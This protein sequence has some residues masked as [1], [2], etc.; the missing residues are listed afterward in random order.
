VAHRFAEAEDV[1]GVG[2]QRAVLV[3]NRTS[4]ATLG[5]RL[6]AGE[7]VVAL[8]DQGAERALGQTLGQR[9]H[10]LQVREV[11][12]LGIDTRGRSTGALFPTQRQLP[13]LSQKLR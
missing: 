7:G 12:L 6:S 10:A 13:Q 11:Q 3:L 4:R 5:T 2:G 9:R 8:L 1:S